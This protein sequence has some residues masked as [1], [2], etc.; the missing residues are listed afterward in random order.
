MDYVGVGLVTVNARA[1]Q[2]L[3]EQRPPL[4]AIPRSPKL[5]RQAP[6]PLRFQS[7]R[8]LRSGPSRGSRRTPR[9]RPRRARR[10]WCLGSKEPP[11]HSHAGRAKNSGSAKA[12]PDRPA[13]IHR[14]KAL[15]HRFAPRL[16]GFRRPGLVAPPRRV[17]GGRTEAGSRE[18]TDHPRIAELSPGKLPSPRKQHG[19]PASEGRI[20]RLHGRGP[21]WPRDCPIWRLRQPPSPWHVSRSG[22]QEGGAAENSPQAMAGPNPGDCEQPGRVRTAPKATLGACQPLTRAQV[23]TIRAPLPIG[24]LV[25]ACPSPTSRFLET[26][27]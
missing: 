20:H 4:A 2:K 6:R 18:G 5:L 8:E 22:P 11:K 25:E 19:P 3:A 17:M 16:G 23:H 12:A 13:P 7:P 26:P 10:L 9:C 24:R 27:K 15:A 21:A 14:V 1:C